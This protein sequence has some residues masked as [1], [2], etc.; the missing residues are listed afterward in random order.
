MIE[1]II[2]LFV[3]LLIGLVAPYIKEWYLCTFNSEDIVKTEF[4]QNGWTQ[5]RRN[6][7]TIQHIYP[8]SKPVEGDIWINSFDGQTYFWN[9]TAWEPKNPKEGDIWFY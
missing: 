4:T 2:G 6:G 1:G 3:I 8:P 7:V 5:T 9:S